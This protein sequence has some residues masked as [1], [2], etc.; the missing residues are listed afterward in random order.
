VT[1]LSA[2]LRSNQKMLLPYMNWTNED[3]V[4]DDYFGEG[5]SEQERG[6]QLDALMS[7]PSIE[8]FLREYP[9]ETN[10]VQS[11]LDELL[12]DAELVPAKV[13][14]K[15]Q[16]EQSLLSGFRNEPSE[17]LINNWTRSRYHKHLE[18]TY[19]DDEVPLSKYDREASR[20]RKGIIEENNEPGERW[21]DEIIRDWETALTAREQKLKRERQKAS[22][23][24]ILEQMKFR[25]SRFRELCQLLGP[26]Q[27][28]LAFS[29]DLSSSNLQESFFDIV[30]RSNK[31]MD[32]KGMI[33]S[34]AKRLGRLQEKEREYSSRTLREFIRPDSWI[35]QQAAKSSVVGIRESDD[36]SS[37]ISSEVLLLA[38]PETELLFYLKFAEKKLLTY[39]YQPE[40][41]L[42]A[43]AS[44][45]Q[46]QRVPA[47]GKGP[48]ILAV[49]TSASMEGELEMNAKAL[50]LSLT[51]IA[52]SQRRP[53][54]LITFSD[55][56]ESIT[57]SP[58]AS[59][60][61]DTIIQ[62]LLMSFHGGTDPAAALA[63]GLKMLE[64]PSFRNADMV[65]LTDG[66]A[67]PFNPANV[68]AMNAAR[69]RGV[70]FY[71]WLV[72]DYAEEKLLAQLDY[73]WR[74]DNNQLSDLAINLEA[75][76]RH[77]LTA[78]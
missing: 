1:T 77:T 28:Y 42:D 74:Y 46:K 29:W 63:Q 72:G 25:I 13:I 40:K 67:A 14:S 8:S 66:E 73:N 69:E 16:A 62:F 24:Q 12:S 54:H 49:D 45:K 6:E 23:V 7:D 76:R 71:G 15:S 35:P 30:A 3:K 31:L 64:Q 44:P 32:N 43:K 52:L 2:K 59:K 33:T 39:D 56:S 75:Y 19:N 38:S 48:I 20:L 65:F 22:H 9:R 36:I 60:P 78:V 53:V 51:R 50:A 34:I 10:V 27:Q 55:T 4:R 41:E 47:K 18:A 37:M 58:W 57:I 61:L 68:A 21:K 26:I 17:R 11:Q 5:E 70:K